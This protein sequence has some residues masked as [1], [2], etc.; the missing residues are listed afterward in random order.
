LIGEDGCLALSA[1]SPRSLAVLCGVVGALLFGAPAAQAACTSAT[2]SSATFTD[3]A[4]DVEGTAADLTSMKLSVDATCTFA[5]DPGLSDLTVD[6]LVLTYI[7]RDGDTTTGD[8]ELPGVDLV[9]LTLTDGRDSF[10][11]LGW[12]DGTD[13]RVD[14]A[15]IIET[16]PAPGGFSVAV[17]K[18]GIPPGASP[19]FRMFTLRLS[20]TDF[21]FD[22]A[23]DEGAPFALPVNYEGTPVVPTFP[24]PAPQPPTQDPTPSPSP[25]PQLPITPGST[26][27]QG[28]TVPKVS[29]RTLAV[30]KR[31]LSASGCSR[32]ATVTRRYSSKVPKGRVIGTTPGTGSRT[33]KKVKLIVSKG[34]RPKRAKTAAVQSD[35][36]SRARAILR[37]L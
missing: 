32:S 11:A 34:K 14:E 4:N 24:A 19:T 28:C 37:S 3:P 5:F 27:G 10:T 20:E 8:P 18:L 30:A 23:P 33:T 9:T 29:G 13:Y 6:D 21:G 2:P 16:A 17:D 12:W 15:S 26:I 35:P 36:L 22:L 1:M 7:D 25:L 31:R